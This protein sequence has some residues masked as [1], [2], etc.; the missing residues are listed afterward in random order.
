MMN[1]I[2]SNIKTLNGNELFNTSGRLKGGNEAVHNIFESQL[3]RIAILKNKLNYLT[4][5]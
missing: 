3:G 4:A 2:M 5:E 1:D